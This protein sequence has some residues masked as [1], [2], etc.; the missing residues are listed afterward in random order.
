MGLGPWWL[1]FNVMTHVKTIDPSGT[2]DLF[3][4]NIIKRKNSCLLADDVSI[5]ADSR[6]AMSSPNKQL[7]QIIT[8][9]RIYQDVVVMNSVYSK[10]VD[11]RLTQF[12]DIIIDMIG[13]H[14]KSKKAVGQVYW[15]EVNQFT[16]EEYI[17]YFRWRKKK[18]IKYSL[19]PLP[20]DFLIAPYK[21]MRKDKTDA[22]LGGIDDIR[23]GR[24][25]KKQ[26]ARQIRVQKIFQ[27]YYEPVVK[28]RR[29]GKAV[30]AILGLIKPVD[31]DTFLTE[32]WI[33]QILAEAGLE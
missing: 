15:Y 14:R 20:P 4:K 32:Y 29:E 26:T 23:E 17:K 30:K 16:G 6:N 9:S 2:L 25:E 33:K 13:V 10:H 12:A 27:N 7:T 31:R 3:T 24:V 22:F 8:V 19:F 5:S 21:Q 18:R 28:L 1:F 11:K